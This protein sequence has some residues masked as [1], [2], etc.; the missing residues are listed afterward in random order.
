MKI[1]SEKME[2]TA[3][4]SIRWEDVQTMRLLNDKLALVL[5]DNQV[6]EIDHLRPSTVDAAFR[7][8]ESY[9]KEHP[10]KRPSPKPRLKKGRKKA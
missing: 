8:Y 10:E 5:N 3:S 4:E 6:I 2:I 7:A 1:T 9:L